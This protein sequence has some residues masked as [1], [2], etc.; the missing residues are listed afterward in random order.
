MVRRRDG[1]CT[2]SGTGG[3][4]NS[5]FG[6]YLLTRSEAFRKA[7]EWAFAKCDTDGSGRLRRGELYAG[8]LLVHI[9][10]AKYVGPAACYPPSRRAIDDLFDAGDAD[11]SGYVDLNEF[12]NILVVCCAQIVSRIL[13]YLLLIVLAVPYL[14]EGAVHA[15]VNFDEWMGWD[16]DDDNGDGVG[17]WWVLSVSPIFRWIETISTWG[18]V[19]EKVVSF[20]IFVCLVP[21]L[22]DLIDRC[23]TKQTA[24]A[25]DRTSTTGGIAGTAKKQ[26]QKKTAQA[27]AT[28]TATTTMGESEIIDGDDEDENVERFKVIIYPT[29]KKKQ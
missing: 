2:T 20:V 18:T 24:A 26:T 8:V 11:G 9:Q 23:S 14:A 1:S 28:T 17:R 16:D 10:L 13:V 6:S 3:T 7:A 12:R 21:P 29:K 22:F 27:K 19:L 4:G 15:M 25:A 5:R